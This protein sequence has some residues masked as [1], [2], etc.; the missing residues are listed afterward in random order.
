MAKEQDYLTVLKNSFYESY[1]TG[2]DLWSKDE[3]LTEIASLLIEYL[4]SNQSHKVLDIGAGNGR[5]SELF[6]N[7]G[8]DYTGIDLYKNE[9]WLNI[10]EKFGDRVEFYHNSFLSWNT[11]KKF[12]A[13]LDNGCF[14]HQDPKEY[15]L[16]LNKIYQLLAS[17]GHIMLGLYTVNDEKEKSSFSQMPSGK[18]K[19]VF[20]ISEITSLFKQVGFHFIESK[21]ILVEKRNRFYLA[22][23]ATK[24]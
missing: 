16:Y 20:T 23:I 22:A 18:Y 9:N 3:G 10:T 7:K 13:V 15:V 8:I 14:H 24:K 17:N 5:H 12:T 11:D 6:V 2:L 1:E 21:R 19:K 4:P